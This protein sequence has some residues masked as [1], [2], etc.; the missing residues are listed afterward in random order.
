M[1]FLEAF[2]WTTAR[3]ANANTPSGRL[4]EP[5]IRS[6]LGD[7]IY[8]A[9][10]FRLNP[11]VHTLNKYHIFR[12]HKSRCLSKLSSGASYTM[13]QLKNKIYMDFFTQ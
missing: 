4:V 2:T 12:R 5:Y 8:S 11:R 7:E 13:F 10:L 6:A 9:F 1:W 3:R